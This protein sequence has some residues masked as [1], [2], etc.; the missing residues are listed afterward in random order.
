LYL[1]LWLAKKQ[2]WQIEKK[3]FLDG[4]TVRGG[5]TGFTDVTAKAG[6]DFRA[7]HNPMLL[8]EEQWKPKRLPIIKYAHGGVAAADFDGDGWYDIFFCDGE[9]SK[10]YRNLRN[11]KFVDVTAKAGLPDILPGVH[12]ALFADFNNDGY[13]DLFLGRSTGE[14]K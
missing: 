4:T 9:H 13:P 10:L 3:E 14:N 7:H 6:I 12:V 8:N 11:G 2:D 1:R 5:A